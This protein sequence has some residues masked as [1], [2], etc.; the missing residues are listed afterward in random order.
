MVNKK[1]SI[2]I[3]AAGYGSRFKSITKKIPKP[4][5]KIGKKNLLQNAL[6]Y[7][8]KLEYYEIIINTFYKHEMI[9]DFIKSNYSKENIIISHEKNL[10]DTAGAVKN[11]LPFFSCNNALILNCDIFWQKDNLNDIK[12]LINSFETSQKCKLLLV[13]QEKAYGI[14]KSRA[15]F[16]VNNSLLK[17][18]KVDQKNYFYTGAQIISLNEIKKYNQEKFSFNL[19]WDGLIKRKSIFGYVVKSKWYHVGDNRGLK[20]AEKLIT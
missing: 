5:I 20:S 6:D 9:H 18:Y 12:N 14:N 1:I 19:V 10:L 7:L 16:F 11:A 2:M 8:L 13:P 17:R 4:L 3:L 15:D